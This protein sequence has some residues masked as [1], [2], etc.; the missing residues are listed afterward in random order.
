MDVSLPHIAFSAT[1]SDVEVTLDLELRSS[2]AMLGRLPSPPAYILV[3]N[4]HVLTLHVLNLQV[5][6]LHVLTCFRCSSLKHVLNL[7]VLNLHVLYHHVLCHFTTYA[8]GRRSLRGMGGGKCSSSPL[9]VPLHGRP[10]L[11]VVFS[12][13]APPRSLLMHSTLAP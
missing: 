2:V 6:N 10:C 5:L 4:F 7:H 12:A 9:S 13:L 8:R 1:L 3:L 11:S